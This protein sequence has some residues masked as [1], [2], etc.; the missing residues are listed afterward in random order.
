[1]YPLPGLR[2][3]DYETGYDYRLRIGYRWLE[4]L[5]RTPGGQHIHRSAGDARPQGVLVTQPA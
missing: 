4:T 5:E 1:M 3:H 2:R